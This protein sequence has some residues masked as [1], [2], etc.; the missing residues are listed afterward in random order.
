MV[1]LI[2][3]PRATEQKREPRI[4]YTSGV[5]HFDGTYKGNENEAE[6]TDGR[7]AIYDGRRC[8]THSDPLWAECLAWIERKNQLQEDFKKLMKGF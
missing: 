7:F 3:F 1:K 6:L 2:Y 8:R 5:A 4:I